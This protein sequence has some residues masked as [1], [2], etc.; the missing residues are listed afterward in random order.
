[1]TRS[2]KNTATPLILCIMVAASNQMNNMAM[3]MAADATA[4]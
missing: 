3:P 2:Q 4:L 1:M